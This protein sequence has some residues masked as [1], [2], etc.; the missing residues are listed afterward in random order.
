MK[1]LVIVESPSKAHTINKYLGEGF[2]VKATVGHIK[3]LPKNTLGVDIKNDFEPKYEIIKGKEKTIE[4]IK[5]IAKNVETVY[6]AADPDREGEAIAWNVKEIIDAIKGKKP[7]VK[8]VLFNEITKDAIKD[9]IKNPSSLNEP[10]Y[11]SQKARRIL[12][13]LVGY[14]LSPFLWEKVRRGLSAGRVQS[15][16]LYL[17]VEREKEI[18]AFKKEEFWTVT[19]LFDIKEEKKTLSIECELFKINGK[20]PKI[21]NEEEVS[22]LKEKLLKTDNYKIE[23]IG[24]KQS[25]RK[26]PLPLITSTLQQEAAKILRFSVK[27]TMTIAQKLYEG[28]ELGAVEGVSNKPLGPVGLI[29]YMRTDSTR[30]SEASLKSAKNFIENSF[31][32]E[33]LNKNE[34]NKGKGKAGKIQDAHEAIRPTDVLLTPKKIKEYLTSDEYK[35][36]NLIWAYFVASLMEGSI[37]DQ[38]SIIIKGDY[39]EPQKG[40]NTAYTFKTTES[41]LNFDGFQKVINESRVSAAA[42]PAEPTSNIKAESGGE[43]QEDAEKSH[44]SILKIFALLTKGDPADIKRVDAFQHFTSPPPRYTEATL[45]K[46]LD[47]NGIGRPSTYQSIIANIKNKDYVAMTTESA[48]TSKKGSSTQKFKPTE[49]GMTVSDILKAG[50]SDIVDLKFTANMESKLDEIEKGTTSR[51]ELLTNFYDQFMKSFGAAKTNIKNIKGTSEPTNIICE[52]CGKPM[53]IKMGRFGKFLA[54]S[55]YPECKNTK[56]IPKDNADND[57]AALETDEICEKCGKPMVIKTGRYGKFLSCSGYPEC[58]NIKPIPVKYNK[59][60]IPCPTGCGGYLVEK[61]TKKGRKFYGCSNY[62]KCDYAAWTLPKPAEEKR[63]SD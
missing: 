37:Y 7:D 28:V 2:I 41:V 3:N 17:I 63:S 29:T 20:E 48:D 13:R 8:R 15:V 36:Y 22:G 18:K 32:K 26:P 43:E 12:D 1:N 44:N 24:K 61:R 21:K 55:G 9:A 23:E 49:L 54:C 16:A 45:V 60:K 33:Y 35:L 50:F 57:A 38:Y 47:E 34:F 52:K 6:L 27:K 30:I 46:A 42:G 5:K 59:S 56:E 51:K 39:N 4:E 10:M 31:G 11:E 58:K 14:N 62:P 19:A 25:F 53:V 40:K